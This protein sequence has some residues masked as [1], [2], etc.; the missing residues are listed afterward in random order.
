MK[1]T[2]LKTLY[3]FTSSL[4]DR[5]EQAKKAAMIIL[6]IL[7]ARSPRI[8]EVARAIPK[9]FF[10]GHKMI[11]RFLKRAP[12]KEA[13]LRLLY[14]D[15]PF[16]ICDP[17]EIPRPQARRT[18]YVGTLKDG[19]TKG[20]QLLVFSSPY[21]GRAIPFWFVVFSSRTISQEES[22][23]NLVHL[24]AFLQVKDLLGERPLVLD[25][26]FSYGRLL[27]QLKGAGIHFVV[28][29]NTARH[30]SFTDKEGQKRRLSL[31][32][33]ERV[34]L[35]GLR[36][37]GEV[38][39]NVAGVWE[40]GHSEPLWV[41]TD[42]SPQEALSIYRK[43]MAIEES[44]RDLKTLLSL[45]KLMNKA[46]EY[47]EGMVAL[48]LMAYGIGLALGEAVRETVFGG[49][50]SYRLYSGLFV[51]LRL[52]VKV[53]Y[54]DIRKIVEQSLSLFPWLALSPVSTHV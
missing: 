48:M 10:A 40:K 34:F 13:L 46:Q 3:K 49:S 50:R 18:P 54:E 17:T 44:F 52:K 11:Y 30:P 36:Y 7:K 29:L 4:F 43:R 19:K 14:E 35:E 51:L 45:E 47:L 15:A 16:V 22:S 41:I 1:L 12:L 31:A 23:R 37:K 24:K 33:G 38:E 2:N 28:R 6:G 26:E 39:V 9:G 42:L 32:C 8:T 21:K 53:S 20:F 25:R 5:E 27:S